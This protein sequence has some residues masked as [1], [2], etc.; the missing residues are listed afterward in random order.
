MPAESESALAV[1]ANRCRH[2]GTAAD[3]RSRRKHTRFSISQRCSETAALRRPDIAS[4]T[5][6]R[7]RDPGHCQRLP[8]VETLF[9][10]SPERVGEQQKCPLLALRKYRGLD[11]LRVNL[12]ERPPSKRG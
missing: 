4:L 1:P 2:T 3:K 10:A 5:S 12:V 8:G 9:A 7:E 11:D 6:S